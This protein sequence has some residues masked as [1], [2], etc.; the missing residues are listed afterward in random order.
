MRPGA[1]PDGIEALPDAPLAAPLVDAV[2]LGVPT[3]STLCPTC[4]LIVVRSPLRRYMTRGS[5]PPVPVGADEALELLCSAPGRSSTNC[6]LSGSA[7]AEL[8][9]AT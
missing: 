6:R 4:G 7:V 1:S 3:I 2:T 9:D 8:L 5:P